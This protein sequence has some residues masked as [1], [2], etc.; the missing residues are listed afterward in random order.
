M[1][2]YPDQAEAKVQPALELAE[3]VNH[4]YTKTLATLLS[5]DSY[6]F[7]SAWPQCLAQAEKGLELAS[8]WH[9]PFGH[10]GCTMHRGAVLARQGQIESGI[11]I[12]R[13]GLDAWIATG[14][15]MALAY[16]HER[17]AEAYLLAGK[18]EEGF[19]AL[20]ESFSHQEEVWWQPEQYRIRA[21]LLLLVPGHEVEAEGWLRQSLQLA[22]RRG[23][24]SLE[25]RSA[26][27]LAR[28]LRQQGRAAEGRDRLVECYSWFTEGF[29]TTDLQEARELLEMLDREIEQASAGS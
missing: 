27:S 5:A 3:E 2:G 23:A 17:L 28:L 10:A 7:L 22:R 12:L 14:T 8:K 18:R 4:P 25:L 26:M 15:R 21:E 16:W 13:L 11:D 1:M 6:H 9:F 20:D 19:E 24:R 29:G